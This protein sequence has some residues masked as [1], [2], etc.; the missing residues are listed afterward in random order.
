ERFARRLR[1]TGQVHHE[2]LADAARDAAGQHPV[3][4][5]RERVRAQGLGDARGLAVDHP[6]RGL[7]GH[8]VRREPRAAGR[9]HDVRF[10]R[11]LADRVADGRHAVR[12]ELRVHDRDARRLESFLDRGSALI[13]ARSGRALRADRDDR[14]PERDHSAVYVP[15]LPPLFSMSRMSVSRAPR[16]TLFSMSYRV[17]PAIATAVSASIS[18]PVGPVVAASAWIARPSSVISTS[19]ARWVSG[20]GCVSGMSSLVFFAAMIP[21]MRAAAI[22]S[23]FFVFPSRTSASVSAETRRRPRAT[24]RRSVSG[25]APTSTIRAAPVSSRWVSFFIPSTV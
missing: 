13:D 11:G 6:A 15:V 22:T 12:D 23:P 7:G 2:G 24:A 17:R 3:G 10:L 1:R 14:G 18:T 5:L 8:V 9:E 16:S 4:R 21:A 25:F 19:T 20:S